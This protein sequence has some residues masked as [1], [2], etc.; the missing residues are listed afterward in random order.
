MLLKNPL[1]RA[2]RLLEAA[3]RMRGSRGEVAEG[4]VRSSLIYDLR[5]WSGFG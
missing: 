4:L 5:D 2:D 1:T 3:D